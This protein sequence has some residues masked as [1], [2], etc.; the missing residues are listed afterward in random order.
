MSS[1]QGRN[2]NCQK[3]SLCPLR[4]RHLTWHF[5]AS[6]MLFFFKKAELPNEE[7]ATVSNNFDSLLHQLFQLSHVGG[8]HYFP[9]FST[10]YDP[11]SRFLLAAW[12]YRKVALLGGVL[13]NYITIT[14][15]HL[16]RYSTIRSWKSIF[17]QKCLQI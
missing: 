2:R 7:S 5:L 10:K 3:E 15:H 9:S 1:I 12:S 17:H 11:P 8:Y 6:F 4:I 13:S 14:V 16:K